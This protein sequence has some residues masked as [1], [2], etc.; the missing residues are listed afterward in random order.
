MNRNL[1]ERL[2]ELSKDYKPPTKNVDTPIKNVDTNSLSQDEM[3][4]HCKQLMQTV[5][6]SYSAVKIVKILSQS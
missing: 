4:N 2:H 1:K 5:G 3:K 6:K